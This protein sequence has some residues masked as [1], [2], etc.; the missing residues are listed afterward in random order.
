MS[1]VPMFPASVCPVFKF[2]MENPTS[3]RNSKLWDFLNLTFK[4]ICNQCSFTP[5]NILFYQPYLH[6]SS[7]S[8]IG[9]LGRSPVGDGPSFTHQFAVGKINCM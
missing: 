5:T 1:N 3:L 4:P 8:V 9:I 7:M 6:S 2:I